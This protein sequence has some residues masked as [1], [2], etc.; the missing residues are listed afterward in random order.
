MIKNIIDLLQI[1]KGETENIQI[2]QGK[3]ALPLSV[4]NGYKLLK[5]KIKWDR[6]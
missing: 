2:A 3:N 4:K 6:K 1:A 5:Q